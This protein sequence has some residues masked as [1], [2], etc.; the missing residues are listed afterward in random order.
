MKERVNGVN[1]EYDELLMLVL[2][3]IGLVLTALFL[4]MSALRVYYA[5]VMP[6]VIAGG[7]FL[8]WGLLYASRTIRVRQE[9]PAARRLAAEEK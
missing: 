2:G 6:A 7:A 5:V 1:G 4:A 9:A 8:A 3:I